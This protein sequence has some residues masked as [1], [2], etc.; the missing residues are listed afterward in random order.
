MVNRGMAMAKG[1]S[2]CCSNQQNYENFKMDEKNFEKAKRDLRSHDPDTRRQ[3][4]QIIRDIR[5]CWPG[6]FQE[7]P[8]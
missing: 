4:E 1:H 6:C 2:G 5:S 7:C 3:A 8:N